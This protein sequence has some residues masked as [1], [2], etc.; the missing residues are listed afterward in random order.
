MG[1]SS[2][3][4]AIKSKIENEEPKV[5]KELAFDPIDTQKELDEIEKMTYDP[6][7]T[8]RE[9]EVLRNTLIGAPVKLPA[10]LADQEKNLGADDTLFEIDDPEPNA[11]KMP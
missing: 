11:P 4:Q 7:N 8:A 10:Q 9:M 1:K 5:D 3:W 6:N 2:K